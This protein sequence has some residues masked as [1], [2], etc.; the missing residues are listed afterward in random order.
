LSGKSDGDE[1]VTRL[2]VLLTCYYGVLL[3]LQWL[4]ENA[5]QYRLQR[6]FSLVVAQLR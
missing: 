2:S 4:L 5:V 6:N 1:F 3:G